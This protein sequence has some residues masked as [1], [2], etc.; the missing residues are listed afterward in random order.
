MSTETL[1]NT[2]DFSVTKDGEVKL[3]GRSKVLLNNDIYM[4]LARITSQQC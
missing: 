3:E 2:E 4:Q 1:N